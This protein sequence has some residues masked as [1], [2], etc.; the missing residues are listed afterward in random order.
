[1]K[2]KFYDKCGFADPDSFTCNQDN[3]GKYCGKYRLLSSGQIAQ[4]MDSERA[5][6]KQPSGQPSKK[7]PC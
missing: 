7:T 1:M 2:C 4:P 6:D 3:G 5:A